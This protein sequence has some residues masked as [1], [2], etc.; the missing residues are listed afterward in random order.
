VFGKNYSWGLYAAKNM[1]KIFGYD[2][3]LKVLFTWK[4]IK[5]IF[6]IFKSY[7]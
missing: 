6:F 7:F 4:Y 5:I 2:C 1:Y 3:F